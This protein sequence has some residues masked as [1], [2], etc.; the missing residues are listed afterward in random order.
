MLNYVT[1]IFKVLI[2]F[3]GIAVIVAVGMFALHQNEYDEFV[4]EVSPVIATYGGVN[5]DSQPKLQEIEDKYNNLF[6]VTPPIENVSYE[7]YTY[8][9]SKQNQGFGRTINY[10]IHTQIPYLQVK[11]MAYTQDLTPHI[12]GVQISDTS[13]VVESQKAHD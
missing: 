11:K 3:I 7:S 5:S 2:S 1:T 13:N 9:T 4:K 8:D 12:T 6:I 10:N